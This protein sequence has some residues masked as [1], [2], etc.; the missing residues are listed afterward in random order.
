MGI[1]NSSAA[2][3]L[4]STLLDLP[5]NDCVGTGAGHDAAGIARKQKILRQVRR[6]HGDIHDPRAALAAFGGCEVAMMTGA[7]LAA[8]SRRMLVMVDGLIATA[9]VAVAAKLA[10]HVLDYAVFAHVSGD[11]AHS[12]AVAALGGKPLLNLGLRLGEGTGAA[13]AWPLVVAAA[14]FLNEMA[15]FESASVSARAP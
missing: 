13:L 8:A 11:T 6:H 7:I 1:G 14:A 5:I 2:A 3:L 10:P 9:A 4:Y 15:T 12:H